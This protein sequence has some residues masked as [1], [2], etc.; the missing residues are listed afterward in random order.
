MS[1]RRAGER[2]F[3]A[4]WLEEASGHPKHVGRG[5]V[6]RQGWGWSW[7]A[8]GVGEKRVKKP[9]SENVRV[10]VARKFNSR[11]LDRL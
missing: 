8:G 2:Y 6:G 1:R 7:V 5:R 9:L 4:A 11:P 10:R 3:E